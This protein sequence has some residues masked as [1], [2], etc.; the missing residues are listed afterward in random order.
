M[1]SKPW[2]KLSLMLQKTF[3]KGKVYQFLKQADLILRDS[4]PFKEFSY[5]SKSS[6]LVFLRNFLK[7]Q[8]LIFPDNENRLHFESQVV[9]PGYFS[10]ELIREGSV[11]VDGGAFPG[12]FTIIASRFV[13]KTGKVYAF[14]PDPNN[15]EYLVQMLKANGVNGNVEI[16]PKGIY[17]VNDKVDFSSNNV[18][19]GIVKTLQNKNISDNRVS[20]DTITLDTF[21]DAIGRKIDV[22]KMDIEGAEISA[23]RGASKLIATQKPSF[24]IA[25]YHLQPAGTPTFVDLEKSLKSKY[26]TVRTVYQKHLT[27]F[28]FN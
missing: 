9:L 7:G 28:A 27:T 10:Y 25:S 4:Y 5:D 21:A 16:V 26:S 14:E 8:K 3:P 24:M 2:D 17:G 18:S 13:G 11:V 20:I 15:R 23:L 22:V 6:E 19:S 12:D 1:I